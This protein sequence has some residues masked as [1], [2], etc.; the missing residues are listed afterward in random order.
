MP[1]TLPAPRRAARAGAIALLLATGVGCGRPPDLPLR[2]GINP[3]P[4]YELL[5]LAAEK[6]FFEQE[7]VKVRL[8][9]YT[10]LGD[11]R[12]AFELGRLD[13]MTCT[14]IE[15]SEVRRRTPLS[16]SAVLVLDN[17]M[18]ADV[19]LAG[20]GTASVEQLRGRR[21]GV[22]TGSLG[23]YLLVRA[24]EM[25]G[26]RMEDVVLVASDPPSMGADFAG[27][28][29]DAI[30]SYPPYA[31]EILR[32]GRAHVLFSSAQIPGEVV[33]V[34]AVDAAAAAHRARELT[35]VIRAWER[36]RVYATEHADETQRRMAERERVSPEELR[37][38]L[39]AIRILPLA[40]QPPL[41]APGAALQQIFARLQAVMRAT[42]Q[43]S[44]P[45]ASRDGGPAVFISEPLDSALQR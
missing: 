37:A 14:L 23:V 39:A 40:E 22:E 6:G 1:V 8:V 33:D 12:R 5:Y 7:G 45:A 30:V 15:L 17:S 9:E 42:G 35:G 25:Y 11:T 2:I 41:F 20:P 38:S 3:W 34:L 32:D 16:P 4:G 24:L 28:T 10:S 31:T 36:A 13:G 18:G 43:D 29:L 44:L 21:V 26:L 19:L 27:G